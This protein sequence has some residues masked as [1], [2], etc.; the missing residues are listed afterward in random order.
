[1]R[2][3]IVSARAQPPSRPPPPEAVRGALSQGVRARLDR[4]TVGAGRRPPMDWL[5]AARGRMRGV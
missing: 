3:Y 5:R 4:D 1:V 2:R